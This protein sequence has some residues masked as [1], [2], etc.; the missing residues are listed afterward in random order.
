MIRVFLDLDGVLVN[1][2][3]G[4][5]DKYDLE[6]PT[7]RIPQEEF[8]AFHDKLF[9]LIRQDGVNF[10]KS[11]EP[12]P[13]AIEMFEYFNSTV[14]E[15]NILTAWP[16]SFYNRSDQLSASLGKKFWVEDNLNERMARR[17]IVCFA[18]DKFHQVNRFP[19]D[20]NVL[21]DDM[22]GNIRDW[23]AAGGVGI[24]HTSPEK[25]IEE[26]KLGVLSANH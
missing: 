1:F 25:T 19:N 22:P 21:I 20:I 5:K 10:W 3:K 24:L 16:H 4:I 9:G 11:L 14:N 23:N 6:Y 15:L 7:T 2:A 8:E 12:M 26:F 17:T 13:G 18:K